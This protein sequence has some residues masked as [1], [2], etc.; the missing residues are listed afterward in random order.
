MLL[1]GCEA[2]DGASGADFAEIFGEDAVVGDLLAGAQ[3]RL[4]LVAFPLELF[5][6]DALFHDLFEDRGGAR[7]VAELRLLAPQEVVGEP[8]FEGLAQESLLFLAHAGQHPA[9][10]EGEAERDH[11]EFQEGHPRLEAVRHGDAVGPL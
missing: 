8:A 2:S 3:G 1:C 6:G 4:D 7:A 10:G 5:F 11:V 9:G